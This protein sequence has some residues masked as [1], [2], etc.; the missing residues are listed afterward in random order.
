MR[1]LI[2]IA[3]KEYREGFRNRW[4][5]SAT[6]LLA[7][8]ALAL[9]FLGSAPT[10][11]VNADR[12]AVTVVSLASL[13]V[14]LVPLIALLLSFEALVGE[15]ERG[16]MLLLL[17]YPVARWQ[18][19][20]GKFLGHLLILG[21]AI[22]V[23]YGS[24]GLAAGLLAGAETASWLAL[25]EL[26]G[27]SLL[28]G[29]IFIALGYLVSV[30]A[31]DRGFAAGLAVGL[32]LL[33]V[34]LYDLALLGALVADEGHNISGGLFQALLTANPADA[35]RMLNFDDGAAGA[36]SGLSGLAAQAAPG[37]SILLGSM[38]AWTIAALGTAVLIFSRKEL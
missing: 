29:T 15:I 32:W 10:G 6:I 13:S 27:T 4:V 17:A 8:L 1:T 25:G 18:I 2:I 33:I 35:F 14:F 30:V 12:L 28:L 19:V 34:V 11:T 38:A 20:G 23:G 3:G 24:A 31:R 22:V 21:T 16:T 36:M 5:L 26:I 9:A 37:T 7:I